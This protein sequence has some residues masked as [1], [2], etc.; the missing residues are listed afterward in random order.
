MGTVD[1][2]VGPRQRW[3]GTPKAHT[4]H[5][6]VLVQHRNFIYHRRLLLVFVAVADYYLLLL[7]SHS[8]RYYFLLISLRGCRQTQK[9]LFYDWWL[10]AL[11]TA[12]AA[13]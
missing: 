5:P 6:F 2:R 1:A 10:V 4:A 8:H 7:F 9:I 3:H 13:K 11:V 12:A